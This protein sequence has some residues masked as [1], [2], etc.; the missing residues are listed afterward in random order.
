MAGRNVLQEAFRSL[1][2]P[3]N[4]S[5]EDACLGVLTEELKELG[6]SHAECPAWL[7]DQAARWHDEGAPS[8]QLR[9]ALCK[10]IEVGHPDLGKALS[11][12]Y[13]KLHADLQTDHLLSHEQATAFLS[14]AL[15][16][17]RLAGEERMSSAQVANL[18]VVRDKRVNFS[19]Q[20]V[21]VC[22]S[23]LGVKRPLEV[24]GVE[25]L[26]KKDREQEEAVFA[27]A[28][29]AVGAEI[30][31]QAAARLLF[32]NDM[33][34]ALQTLAREDD[35][36]NYS[37]YLQMLHYQCVV[38]EFYDHAVTDLYEFN[39]RGNAVKWLIRQYPRALSRA[40]N[41]FLNNAKSVER[42]D[43]SWARSKKRNE[44]PG[45]T[46]LLSILEGLESM[47]F[48]A[49]QELAGL[50]RCWL[51]RVMRLAVPAAVE[52]PK[53]FNAGQI[54]SVLKAIKSGNS[55]TAGIIEQRVVDALTSIRHRKE[56]GWRSRGIGDS[57]NA[58]N[59]SRKKLGDCDYQNA[60]KRNVVAYEAHA[61]TLTQTYLDEHVRTL[62]KAVRLRREEWSSFSEPDEWQ[63][64]ILFIAHRLDVKRRH[65]FAVEGVKVEIRSVTFD[66]LIGAG[67][68]PQE[69]VSSFQEHVMAPLNEK[70]TP[71][72]ARKALRAMAIP[73]RI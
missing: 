33:L 27:D 34:R 56:D 63:V 28:D 29:L 48:A 4:A 24:D 37:P 2:L 67:P 9:D 65:A 16:M 72:H 52:L 10:A 12:R 40:G 7:R 51:H 15:L 60:D 30:V 46:A 11:Q 45:A 18:L 26:F 58:T 38:A 6:L 57:V 66:E 43:G 69:F 23:R 71:D 49:R 41:P 5:L 21:D 70:R 32:P 20:S 3:I 22:V 61:G 62:E 53:A 36:G 17:A 35:I 64:D 25:S 55:N 73:L 39:P 54:G 31:S 47:G 8:D 1:L 14:H 50:L 68:M 59:I 19:R 44:R 42:V 13:F